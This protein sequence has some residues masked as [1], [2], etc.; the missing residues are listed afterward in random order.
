MEPRL[1]VLPKTDGH[2]EPRES[3]ARKFRSNFMLHFHYCLD[4]FGFAHYPIAYDELL[5]KY[6]SCFPLCRSAAKID[7]LRVKCKPD[8]RTQS[9]DSSFWPSHRRTLMDAEGVQGTEDAEAEDTGLGQRFAQFP[10][11]AFLSQGFSV[12]T[13]SGPHTATEHKT[14]TETVS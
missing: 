10:S 12:H 7:L 2:R 8:F 6:C 9:P 11:N 1:G 13:S 4:L 14:M 3:S 5:R